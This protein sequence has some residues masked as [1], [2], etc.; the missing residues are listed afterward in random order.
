MPL[1]NKF[2]DVPEDLAA[3]VAT[4]AEKVGFPLG[5]VF[6]MDGSKRSRHSN[7]FIVGLRG[8]RKIVLYDTLIEEIDRPKLIAVLA[9]ELGHFKLKH[10][11]K[12]LVLIMTGLFAMFFALSVMKEMDGL[13]AGLGFSRM[14]DHAALVVFSLMVSEAIAPFGWIMRILSRKDEKAADRFAVDTTGDAED[15]AEALIALNKQNLA[16]PGSNALYRH[17]HNSHPA[18]KERL[19]AIRAHVA[20]D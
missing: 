5:R 19:R 13:Y 11:T 10:L 9:H 20:S 15:L 16:S 14:T 1:F 4:L 3:E 17:Y 8:A 7:A 18:L 6:A 2:T 12:R